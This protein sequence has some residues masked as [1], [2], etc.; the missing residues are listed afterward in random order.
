MQSAK[1]EP[2]K[3][4]AVTYK[5]EKMQRFHVGSV[6]TIRTGKTGLQSNSFARGRIVL[7][8]VFGGQGEVVDIPIEAVHG[9][10]TEYA[11]L[12]AEQERAKAKQK[13]ASDAKDAARKRLWMLLCHVAGGD[14]DKQIEVSSWDVRIRDEAVERLTEN[15]LRQL[16]EE[17]PQ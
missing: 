14:C 7:D 3:I 1:I 9:L 10:Y 15:L 5:G 17:P 12:V 11:E 2:G 16:T 8:D 6:V 13:A 4:Y